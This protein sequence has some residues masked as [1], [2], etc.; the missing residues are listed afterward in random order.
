MK[1]KKIAKLLSGALVAATL[2]TTLSACSGGGNASDGKSGKSSGKTEKITMLVLG[3]KPTNG[4]YQ[5]MLKE[6]NK[7]FQEKGVN[8]ELDFFYVEWADWQTQYNTQLIAGDGSV[9]LITTATDWLYAWENSGKGAF[10]ELTDDLLKENAPKTFEQVEKDGDWDV[11][12]YSD[13]KVYFIPEDNYT[14]FTNHGFFYR[15][16]WAEEA[17]F[18]DGEITKFE[19]FTVYF[20]YVLDNKEDVIPWDVTGANASVSPVPIDAYVA[21]HA[22]YQNL[23]GLSAGNYGLW[24]TTEDEPYTI[25]SAL[26][27]SDEWVEGAKL[28]KEWNDM[29]VWR[30]DVLN[31]DGDTREEFFS[32]QSATDQHHA[33]TFY[34]SIYDNM[35]KRQEGSNP[36]FFYWGQENGNV[37]RDIKTHGAMA[38]SASSKHPELALQV[39][40][41]IRNDEECYRLIN[42]GIEGTDYVVTDDGKLDY[43]EGY[44]STKDALEANFWGGRMDEFELDKTTDMPT[45]HEMI[46]DLMENSKNY[47]YENL[48]FNKDQIESYQAGFAS[49]LAEYIPQFSAGKFDDVEGKVKEMRQK[50]KDAGYDEVKEMLQKDMDEWAKDNKVSYE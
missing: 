18:K 24:N 31:Y 22:K 23:L 4:R 25:T 37:F 36:K 3:N 21:G 40:D 6:L 13:G 32:G 20:Q 43:P 50:I 11:V 12:K 29:G 9:D 28:A 16:D 48:I 2:L 34:G 14:Q 5:N 19:D 38:V 45:K 41:L 47:P 17:G 15:G 1:G 7:K 39:Y 49:I 46:D 8:A 30:E 44:D 26:M 33:Q 42:Y 27:E 35:T 10:L